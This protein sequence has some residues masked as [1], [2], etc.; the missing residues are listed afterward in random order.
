MYIYICIY[1]VAFGMRAI[2]TYLKASSFGCTRAC[3]GCIARAQAHAHAHAR[4]HARYIA[5]FCERRVVH[6]TRVAAASPPSQRRRVISAYVIFVCAVRACVHACV[7]ACVS[8]WVSECVATGVFVTVRFIVLRMF[9]STFAV[10]YI[11]CSKN[12]SINFSTSRAEFSSL[13]NSNYF[14]ENAIIWN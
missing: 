9:P 13:I 1:L 7:R 11:G 12:V 3:V 8:E 2:C 6:A 4:T 5:A 10:S 14:H